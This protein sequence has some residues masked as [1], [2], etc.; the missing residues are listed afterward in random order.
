MIKKFAKPSDLKRQQPHPSY[1]TFLSVLIVG[2]LLSVLPNSV[3]GGNS[4]W[5][6]QQWQRQQQQWQQQQMMQQRQMQQQQEMMRRQQQMQQ[7]QQQMRQQQQM[8]QQRQMQQ[9]QTQ[10]QLQQQQR[11]ANRGFQPRN[12]G[13]PRILNT[14]RIVTRPQQTTTGSLTS[15]SSPR[16]VQAKPTA[17]DLTYKQKMKDRLFLIKKNKEERRLANLRKTEQE[18]NKKDTEILSRS[19][20]I[21]SYGDWQYAAPN[22]GFLNKPNEMTLSVGTVIDRYGKGDGRFSSPYKT[23]LEKR[24]TP[25]G[26]E[27]LPYSVYKVIKRIPTLG[28]IVAP[29]FGKEGMGTQYQFEKTMDEL[30]NDGYIKKIN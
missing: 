20:N 3:L 9:Q 16:A 2:F 25:T 8:M 26:T 24:A 27:R 28:G 17:A 13:T 22:N 12:Q 29:A 7:Q 30:V 10:R 1:R 11:S 5:Q 21:K 4:G 19:F 18:K 23:P 6:Q 15:L 14:P